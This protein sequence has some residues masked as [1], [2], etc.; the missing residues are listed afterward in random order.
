MD[1]GQLTQTDIFES[2]SGTVPELLNCL[3]LIRYLA[4]DAERHPDAARLWHTIEAEARKAD[5]CLFPVIKNAADRLRPELPFRPEL[6][7][8]LTGADERALRALVQQLGHVPADAC[9]PASAQEPHGACGCLPCPGDF[10]TPVQIAQWLAELLPLDRGGSLYD[11]CCGSGAMLYGAARSDPGKELRLYGQAPDSS[12]FF[13]CRM[14]LTLRGLHAELG[15]HPANALLE[16]LY[17]DT[18]FDYIIAN[19]PFR[20]PRRD[21]SSREQSV[22]PQFRYLPRKNAGFTWL[23]LILDHLAPDGRAAVLM[24][25]GTLTAQT[26]EGCTLRRQVL[27]AGW[28]EAIL[29]L[30]A[31]LFRGTRVPCCAWV[32][33]RNPKRDT[34]LFVDARQMNL[35][36]RQDSQKITELFRRY[37]AGEPLP[38]AG[39]YAAA[40]IAEIMKKDCMLSPNLYTPPEALSVPPLRQLSDRFREAAEALCAVLPSPALCQR[41]RRWETSVLPR[42][43]KELRLPEVYSI[44][45]GVC[46]R[47]DAFGTEG[48]PMADV[49]TVIHHM[50]L[51]EELPV[52]VQLPDGGARG[53]DLCAGDILLNRTSETIEELACGCAVLKDCSAVYGAFLKRLRPCG[54][55][56][57]DPRYAA[58][59]F[60]SRL[61]RQEVRRV[62]VVCTTLASINLRQLSMLRIYVPDPI[63]QKALGQTLEDAVRFGQE[64]PD[65]ELNAAIGQFADA[66]IETFITYPIALFQKEREQG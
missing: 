28:A 6:P 58:A 49:K 62:S 41:I 30:P 44:T 16:D 52:R 26:I 9:P 24:P 59:Y 48:V 35:F 42:N 25:N 57:I 32:L 5:G 3:L 31:G 45:G 34:V 13:V 20:F 7:K 29:A 46:A 19:P 10:Y 55:V 4:L 36:S 47:K 33:N 65:E 37:R 2:V 15:P 64:Q 22:P 54:T 27:K 1:Y 39:W 14:N 8:R 38:A 50:F 12:S 53:Y 66:F 21:E 23:R 56:G 63:W 40:S 61:Y 11:P 18:R 51:P 17:P 43:W 60:N